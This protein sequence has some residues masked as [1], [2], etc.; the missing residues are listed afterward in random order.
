M[1]TQ[2]ILNI[3]KS[4]DYFVVVAH[5]RDN[6]EHDSLQEYGQNIRDRITAVDIAEH[7]FLLEVH[8]SPKSAASTILHYM[9]EPEDFIDISLEEKVKP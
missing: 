3:I 8:D 6:G 2:E 9:M 4:P 5:A 7:L 1:E